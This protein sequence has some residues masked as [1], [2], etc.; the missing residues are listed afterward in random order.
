MNA[1]CLYVCGNCHSMVHIAIYVN[2]HARMKAVR[3][4]T[5][6]I[7]HNNFGHLIRDPDYFQTLG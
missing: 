7:V 4:S 1:G 2:L 5:C 6:N 3:P